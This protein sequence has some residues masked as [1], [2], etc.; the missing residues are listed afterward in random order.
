MEWPEDSADAVMFNSSL[1][2]ETEPAGI[3]MAV[4]GVLETGV[5]F[6]DADDLNQLF[7]PRDGWRFCRGSVGT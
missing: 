3:A 5:L 6:R 2:Q 7:V 4:S 1:D